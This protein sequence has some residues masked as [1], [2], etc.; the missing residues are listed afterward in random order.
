MNN[1]FMVAR[2]ICG[3]N[4]IL[5]TERFMLKCNNEKRARKTAEAGGAGGA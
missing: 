4:I 5:F 3:V 1:T 2:F